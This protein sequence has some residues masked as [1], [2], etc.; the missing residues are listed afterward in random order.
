MFICCLI[1]QI[2]AVP[3]ILRNF[4]PLTLGISFIPHFFYFILLEIQLNKL[5]LLLF[6]IISFT[7]SYVFYLFVVSL[8]I[9]STSAFHF[10]YFCIPVN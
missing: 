2:H 1:Q 8:C 6:S 9:S 10:K 7:L 3:L 5:E 4:E